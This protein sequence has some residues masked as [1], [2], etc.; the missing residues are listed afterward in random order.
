[1]DT[2]GYED[3]TRKPNRGL[4]QIDADQSQREY[5]HFLWNRCSCFRWFVC[6]V[7]R[8]MELVRPVSLL[9]AFICVN[10]RLVFSFYLRVH[11]HPTFAIASIGAHRRLSSEGS[12]T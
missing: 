8:D 6:A 5:R 12:A 7:P 1:M 3:K 11:S 9:S 2:N 10:P 4:T